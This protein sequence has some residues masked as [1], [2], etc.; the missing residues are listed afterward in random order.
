MPSLDKQMFQED[1]W[2]RVSVFLTT[3]T[4]KM[5]LPEPPTVSEETEGDVTH[6]EFPAVLQVWRGTKTNEGNEVEIDERPH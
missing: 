3:G 6:F 2:R 4:S 1:V 5:L